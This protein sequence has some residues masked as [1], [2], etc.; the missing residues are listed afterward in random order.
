MDSVGWFFTLWI[1]FAAANLVHWRFQK[2]E[3][4]HYVPTSGPFLWVN[5]VWIFLT[6][7]SSVVT[8]TRISPID[9]FGPMM[10]VYLVSFEVYSMW[11]RGRI[12]RDPGLAKTTWK[13][14]PMKP[15]PLATRFSITS[16]DATAILAHMS[17]EE[18]AW[19]FDAIIKNATDIRI[20]IPVLFIFPLVFASMTLAWPISA[21]LWAGFVIV[22]LVLMYFWMKKTY[23]QQRVLMCQTEWAKAQ[24]FTPENLR[25]TIFS[26]PNQKSSQ[27]DP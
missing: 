7:V 22:N 9:F 25:L 13:I 19:F 24:G 2:Q 8:L 27:I 10:I 15:S 20:I 3:Q 4:W 23:Q 11:M 17:P 18:Q 16:S 5:L 26:S 21:A 1:L 12:R 6:L 14:P